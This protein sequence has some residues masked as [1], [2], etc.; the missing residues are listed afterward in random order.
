MLNSVF[1]FI[2]YIAGLLRVDSHNGLLHSILRV[3]E[4]IMIASMHFEKPNA[5][6]TLN[7]Q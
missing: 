3:E 2:L 1:L 6:L 4:E 5:A 7:T